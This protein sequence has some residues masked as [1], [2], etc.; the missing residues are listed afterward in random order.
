MPEEAAWQSLDLFI[1]QCISQISELSLPKK[2][3]SG[4]DMIMNSFGWLPVF[5]CRMHRKIFAVTKKRDEELFDYDAFGIILDTYNDNEN[6]LA[7]FTTPTGL[8]TDYTISND[9]AGQWRR[10]RD[11]SC[12]DEFKLEHILG[13][14]NNKG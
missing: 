13:C 4:S 14:K 1:L 12:R 8:R 3:K 7:F 5:T 6:G 10:T 11:G 2:V 9:A